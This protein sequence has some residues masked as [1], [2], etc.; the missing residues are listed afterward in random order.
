MGISSFYRCTK[1]FDHMMY[2][3]RDMEHNTRT[4]RQ[5]DKRTEKVAYIE[6]GTPPKKENFYK[7]KSFTVSSNSC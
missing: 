5:T 7:K 2:S 4:D 3:S 6:V 1:N